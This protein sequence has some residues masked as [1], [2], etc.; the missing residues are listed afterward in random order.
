VSEISDA[1]T[2]G[3]QSPEPVPILHAPRESV[4]E[5]VDH[6]AALLTCVESLAAGVGPLAVDVE[7]AGGYR[8]TQRAYLLQFRRHDS[9]TWLIDPIAVSDLL[10]LAEVI[11]ELEWVL[12]AAS[13]DLPSL[14]ELQLTPRSLFDTELAGRLLNLDRVGL[15]TMTE[16]YLGYSLAKAHSAADWSTRPLPQ[17]WLTYAALDVEPLI[18]LHTALHAELLD[19]DRL[20]WAREEFN[21]LLS[22]PNPEPRVDPWRR[23]KGLTTRSPRAL[24]IAR[25]L[26]LARDHIARERDRAPGRVL[27][28]TGLAALVHSQPQTMTQLKALP[29]MRRQ[30]GAQLRVWLDA[31]I[32]A[33]ALNGPELPSRRAP[34]SEVPNP[35]SWER[36]N[37]LAAARY[38]AVREHLTDT[39]E[40]LEVPRENLLSPKIVRETVWSLTTQDSHIDGIQPHNVAAELATRGARQWQ[41]SLVVDTVTEAL[42]SARI[43]TSEVAATPVTDKHITDQ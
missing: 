34:S 6:H 25:E 39:A 17:S 10:P 40:L 43:D 2:E 12:H 41:I 18:E 31:I 23:I 26:W 27:P 8:Y 38:N 16:N 37:P 21:Y 9:G 35:R 29:E 14:R 36:L 22:A 42:Q 33:Q 20:E 28:D 5:V 13:Q 1:A 19:R 7:R 32:R 24:A 4:P 30:P 11:N 3:E 15:A